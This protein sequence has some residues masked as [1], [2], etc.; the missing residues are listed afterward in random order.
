MIPF[1]TDFVAVTA[2]VLATFELARFIVWAG[3]MEAKESHDPRA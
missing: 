2:I 3:F 1:L